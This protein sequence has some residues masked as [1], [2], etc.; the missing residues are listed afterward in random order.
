MQQDIN[1]VILRG[2]VGSEPELK[3]VGANGTALLK[4]SVCTSAKVR[5]QDV[6]TW[7]NVCAW[8]ALAEAVG[9]ELRKG[10]AVLVEGELR[11][12]SYEAKSGEKRT[13]TEIVALAVTPLAPSR[14]RAADAPAPDRRDAAI[15]RS[16]HDRPEPEQPA[17]Q[18]LE[19][20]ASIDELPF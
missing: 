4:F 15:Q 12:R 7:H 11:V 17:Q 16:K 19:A 9:P 3:N 14:S 6:A 10:Q 20:P 1:R 18:W 8:G 5:E 13:V 2:R